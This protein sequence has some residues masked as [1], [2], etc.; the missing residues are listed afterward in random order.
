V[1]KLSKHIQEFEPY[2]NTTQTVEDEDNRKFYLSSVYLPKTCTPFI[3][4]KH[5]IMPENGFLKKKDSE[6]HIALLALKRLYNNGY[7]D[8]YLFPKIGSFVTK[9]VN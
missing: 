5:K 1:K 3:N 4:N 6:N 2:Y 8:D 9:K 7:L